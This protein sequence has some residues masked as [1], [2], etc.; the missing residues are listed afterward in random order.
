MQTT[1]NVQM[2]IGGLSEDALMICRF[3]ENH[4]IAVEN[5][6]RNPLSIQ[7]AAFLN[8]PDAVLISSKTK[9]LRQLCEN[10]RSISN[11]PYILLIYENENFFSNSSVNALS[12]VVI[13]SQ[14]DAE[15]VYTGL[16]ECIAN[17][18]KRRIATS[19]N[20]KTLS[21]SDSRLY[22]EIG[23]ILGRLCVTPNYNGYSYLLESIKT[24][25]TGQ[26]IFKGISKQIYPEVAKKLGVTV[27]GVERNIRT[28]IHR[29]WD[30]ASPADKL[31]FFG[32][33]SL[34]ED[35][36]PTNG[37]YIFIIAEK[38]RLKMN[39]MEKSSDFVTI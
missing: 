33:Y 32:T 8:P 20:V 16:M 7:F 14:K 10:F 3:L 36:V 1:N 15:K 12:D 21:E 19:E 18:G 6:E 28:A 2:L 26:G 29:S 11:P 22:S 13:S 38:I 27:S 4:G 39:S 17:K 35:W 5:V 34:K 23:E 24:A 37:E 31:E 9:Y 25:V 30:R